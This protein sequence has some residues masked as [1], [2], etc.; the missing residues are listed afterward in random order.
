M[1]LVSLGLTQFNVLTGVSIAY[2]LCLSSTIASIKPKNVINGSNTD[3]FGASISR[4]MGLQGAIRLLKCRLLVYLRGTDHR[5][6]FFLSPP[7][8]AARPPIL[9][10]C[11]SKV[12]VKFEILA[13]ILRRIY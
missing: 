7:H 9:K 12:L 5:S 10:S 6:T 13:L 4:L 11:Y 8:I 3:Y 1:E 2:L